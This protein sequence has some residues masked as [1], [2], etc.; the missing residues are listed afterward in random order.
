VQ[1]VEARGDLGSGQPL[2]AAGGG[3]WSGKL[4]LGKQGKGAVEVRATSSQGTAS[5]AVQISV[6]P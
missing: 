6:G 1:S 2:A 3:L 4:A 5:H